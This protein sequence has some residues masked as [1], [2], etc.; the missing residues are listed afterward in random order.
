MQK[1]SFR[2][3]IIIL[4]SVLFFV[5]V[6]YLSVNRV[7]AT[8]IVNPDY[9]TFTYIGRGTDG[10]TTMTYIS[11]ST[12]DFDYFSDDAVVDDAIYFGWNGGRWD[13][14][15]LYV[16]TAFQADSVTFVWEYWNGDE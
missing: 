3:T 2:Y 10:G 15:K 14:L 5:I 6:L 1:Y 9:E 4:F 8:I 13:S 16:G 7:S 12:T 11:P